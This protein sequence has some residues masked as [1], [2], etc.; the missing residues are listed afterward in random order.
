MQSSACK[1][2]ISGS[3][4]M[5]HG[6][7]NFSSV[8]LYFTTIR[9]VRSFRRYLNRSSSCCRVQNAIFHSSYAVK[10][11]SQSTKYRHIPTN[12][13]CAQ[14]LKFLVSLV[15]FC[16]QHQ[17]FCGKSSNSDPLRLQPNIVYNY[18]GWHISEC[19]VKQMFSADVF[20]SK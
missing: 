13:L 9:N 16:R 19:G 10:I 3:Q 17:Q 1:I 12:C 14:S 4:M 6:K 7:C 8:K 18:F 5:N 2:R 15:L 20:H 11:P